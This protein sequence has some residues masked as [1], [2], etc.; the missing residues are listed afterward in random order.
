MTNEADGERRDDGG[1][2]ATHSVEFDWD[3]ELS[4]GAVVTSAV[5]TV[6]GRDVT[7]LPPLHDVVDVDALDK[8][9]RPRRSGERRTNGSV[10]FQFAG[11]TVTVYADGLLVVRDAEN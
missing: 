6:S 4:I 2:D 3:D 7:D 5:E 9:F 11:Y 1:H 8:L 10:T